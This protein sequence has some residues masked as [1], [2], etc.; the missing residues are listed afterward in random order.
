MKEL[1]QQEFEVISGAGFESDYYWIIER[2]KKDGILP[3][4]I[5]TN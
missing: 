4:Q 1:S 3:P 5:R 2:L